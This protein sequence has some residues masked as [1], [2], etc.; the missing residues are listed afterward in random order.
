MENETGVVPT[1]LQRSHFRKKVVIGISI[2]AGAVLLF[3]AV[4]FRQE[5]LLFADR[6]SKKSDLEF[7]IYMVQDGGV[8]LR[9]PREWFT[10][11]EIDSP[12]IIFFTPTKQAIS[13]PPS[14]G[15]GFDVAF[16]P[17]EIPVSRH[18]TDSDIM[19]DYMK[20]LG[21]SKNAQGK[22]HEFSINGYSAA[23]QV[24][25]KNKFTTCILIALRENRIIQFDFYSPSSEWARYYPVFKYVMDH[26]VIYPE[27]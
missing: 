16:F 25:I 24:F 9:Y 20:I 26:I 3:L 1:A 11:N 13:Y 22:V 5:I 27:P 15:V 12:L 7:T 19:L 17:D 23:S 8:L 2:L 6:F 14:A 18:E 10:N 4:I 21:G